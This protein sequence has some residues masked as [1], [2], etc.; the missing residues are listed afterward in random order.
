MEETQG[1]KVFYPSNYT[2][3]CRIYLGWSYNYFYNDN[4][5]PIGIVVIAPAYRTEDPGFQ[6]RQAVRF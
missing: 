2:Y 3:V 4:Y 6:S 5:L 1:K